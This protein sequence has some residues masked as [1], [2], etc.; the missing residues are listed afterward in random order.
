MCVKDRSYGSMLVLIQ[1]VQGNKRHRLLG[2]QLG[3]HAPT[4]HRGDAVEYP[5]GMNLSVRC[6]TYRGCEICD[7]RRKKTLQYVNTV[8]FNMNDF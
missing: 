3:G 7:R 5:S 1:P 4:G 2:E 6:H 8:V